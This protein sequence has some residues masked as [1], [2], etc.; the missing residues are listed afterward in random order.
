VGDNSD[1]A[2]SRLTGHSDSPYDRETVPCTGSLGHPFKKSLSDNNDYALPF[3][4]L[5]CEQM[6]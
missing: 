5:L 3:K 6:S 4:H 2:P 1:F